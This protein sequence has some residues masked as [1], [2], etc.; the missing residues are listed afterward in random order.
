MTYLAPL[1][2][3]LHRQLVCIALALLVFLTAIL[4]WMMET[5]LSHQLETV[6]AQFVQKDMERLTDLLE[7][8]AH[9][10]DNA[11]SVWSNWDD[12]WQFMGNRNS[13]FIQSNFAPNT[14][15]RSNMEFM[16]FWTPSGKLHY[17]F[18]EH[19][20]TQTNG[21]LPAWVESSLQNRWSE[22]Y[23]VLQSGK[24]I[25]GLVIT[26]SGIL[27]L[28]AQPIFHSDGSGPTRRL[29]I[30]GYRMDDHD[31]AE[32]AKIV[33][34]Q[35]TLSPLEKSDPIAQTEDVVITPLSGSQ[36]SAAR[37]LHD[38]HNECTIKVTLTQARTIYTQ[39]KRNLHAMLFM[40][41]LFAILLMLAA[42]G[43]VDLR[44]VRRIRALSNAVKSVAMGAPSS[45]L[46]VAK[47]DDE[48]DSLQREVKALFDNQSAQQ[49]ELLDARIQAEDT[50]MAKRQFLARMS[51]EI[52]TPLNGIIGTT[53]L[54]ETTPMNEEQLEYL[55][56]IQS[57][58]N[59]LLELVNDTLDFSKIESGKVTLEHIPFNLEKELKQLIQVIQPRIAEKNLSF[60]VYVNPDTP[61]FVVGDPYRLRQIL[62]NLL[63]NASKFTQTGHILLSVGYIH[64]PGTDHRPFFNF[65]VEDT[66]TGIPSESQDAIFREFEQ[67][68]STISRHYG[69]SG[70]GLAIC[71]QLAEMMDSTMGVE[72]QPGR[73]SRFW[74]HAH[75]EL[76]P[77]QPTLPTLHPLPETTIVL[78]QPA[79][80]SQSI[81][82]RYMTYWNLPHVA[83]ESLAE[84][85]TWIASAPTL[86]K[87]VLV[88]DARLLDD[89]DS[90]KTLESLYMSA[91][92]P[93]PWIILSK[94][95]HRQVD[96]PGT[97]HWLTRPVLPSVL[98]QV[99]SSIV[100]TVN[101]SADIPSIKPEAIITSPPEPVDSAP[102]VLCH[103]LIVEDN[104]INQKVLERML[105][106]AGYTAKVA[107]HGGEA[108]DLLTSEPFDLVLM[109]CHM[110][111]MDGFEATVKIRASQGPYSKVPIIAVTGNAID[112]ELQKC[113]ASGMNDTITKP[114]HKDAL[115]AKIT[116]WLSLQADV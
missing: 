82:C 49:K 98:H 84:L 108:L 45:L 11:I 41:A 87:T 80:V 79:S 19:L 38:I 72:S 59:L 17:G 42:F 27:V 115:F 30:A 100:D 3:S 5:N 22:W 28:T 56:M 35:F 63:S 36:V 77:E 62:V 51:H 43:V 55:G 12:A 16:T 18:Y 93:R 78:V 24:R 9:E 14:L 57:S 90:R 29:I 70:L 46:P 20:G 23:S 34:S 61:H 106:K 105:I 25:H 89:P 69:G 64:I 58:S 88:C 76:D 109:D 73:G 31:I 114:I 81:F 53:T 48:I 85:Q 32:V 13:G 2:R 52:R 91:F 26:P 37:H 44:I 101:A 21:Q 104:A 94:S 71:K 75:L 111:Q 103:I 4:V 74:F 15:L 10:L 96:L 7:D 66:G 110:P 116:Q 6:E 65:V 47:G 54:L 107:N 67:A 92:H 50:T 83:L 95:N 112:S 33:H 68:D 102:P 97:V 99:L 113:L 60:Y 1:T 8:K 40:V 39:G 86:E